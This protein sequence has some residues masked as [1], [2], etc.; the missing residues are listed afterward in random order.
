MDMD[1]NSTTIIFAIRQF[2]IGRLAE[3]VNMGNR[4]NCTVWVDSRSID[5]YGY[6]DLFV[7]CGNDEDQQDFACWLQNTIGVFD[8]AKTA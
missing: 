8:F 7:A 1:E 3:A 2:P 4:C 6:S 5:E